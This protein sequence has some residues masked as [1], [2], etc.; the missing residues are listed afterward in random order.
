MS[1]VPWFS[2]M[3][4]WL[5]I[6]PCWSYSVLSLSLYLNISLFILLHFLL[7]P[8]SIPFLPWLLTPF[9]LLFLSSSSFF[10]VHL[11]PFIAGLPEV[12][13]FFLFFWEYATSESQ[14]K[15]GAVI[16]LIF[17]FTDRRGVEVSENWSSFSWN[18]DRQ[19]SGLPGSC[20]EGFQRCKWQLQL[21]GQHKW[22]EVILGGRRQ[23]FTLVA[24]TLISQPGYQCRQTPVRVV[25]EIDTVVPQ[26]MDF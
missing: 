13:M 16:F 1:G 8:K 10:F 19:L 17:F 4:Y 20:G 25:M 2:A 26:A 9:L 11:Y 21:L 15:I 12:A 22:V 14:R 7:F 18:S 23:N 3:A 24:E 5:S 6:P